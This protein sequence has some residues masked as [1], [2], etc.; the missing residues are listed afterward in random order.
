MDGDT[1]VTGGGQSGFLRRQAPRGWLSFACGVAALPLAAALLLHTGPTTLLL[2]SLIL[3][4][5]T[6][7]L[8]T[9]SSLPALLGFAL[10]ASAFLA[11]LFQLLISACLT[12]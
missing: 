3:A 11:E 5:T 8:A 10:A 4:S 12:R 1:L 6:L 7:A 9:P 2:N